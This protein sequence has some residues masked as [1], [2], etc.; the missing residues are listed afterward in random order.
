[1]AAIETPAIEYA[2]QRVPDVREWIGLL[3]KRAGGGDLDHR[4]LAPGEMHHFPKVGP[5]LRRRRRYARLLDAH[6]VDD[7]PH[8]GVAVD[9]RRA[10]V[11]VAPEQDVD[12]EIVFDGRAQDAVE[13]RIV[14]RALTLSSG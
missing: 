6:M 11:D 1:Q 4:I 10:R 12:R 7:E 3:R 8:V 9:Q 13:P 2:G 5:G 14:R